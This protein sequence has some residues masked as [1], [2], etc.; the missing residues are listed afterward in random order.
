VI[1]DVKIGSLTHVMDFDASDTDCLPDNPKG[2]CTFKTQAQVDKE[3]KCSCGKD[4]K[5]PGLEILFT[6]TF[7]FKSANK[8]REPDRN[9]KAI[10]LCQL[11]PTCKKGDAARSGCVLEYYDEEL[12]HESARG[13][14]H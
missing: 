6:H 7:Q 11:C 12:M 8:R 10:I 2:T 9:G 1:V 5:C 14:Q 13:W 4:K 3:F